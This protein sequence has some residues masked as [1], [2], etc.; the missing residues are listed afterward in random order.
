VKDPIAELSDVQREI[1]RGA[2]H[3]WSFVDDEVPRQQIDQ[4]GSH[5]PLL[6]ALQL[7]LCRDPSAL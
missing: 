2:L 5:S 1:D 3:C 7:T 6:Q 4:R